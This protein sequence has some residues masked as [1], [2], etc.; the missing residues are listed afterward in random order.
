VRRHIAAGFVPSKLG[1]TWN[2]RVSF[3]LNDKFQVKRVQFLELEREQAGEED[4]DPQEQFD[5]DF[6]VMSG[7]LSKLLGDLLPAISGGLQNQ[8]A[9]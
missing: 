5:L 1:L 8:A 3:Q 9:A 6:A 7:E 2:S 4:V